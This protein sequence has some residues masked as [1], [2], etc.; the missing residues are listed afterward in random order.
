M[1]NMQHHIQFLHTSL[2]TRGTVKH[3]CQTQRH[4]PPA[5]CSSRSNHSQI[6]SAPAC[7]VK[8]RVNLDLAHGSSSGLPS[9][10]QTRQ[11][12]RQCK[13]RSKTTMN[14]SCPQALTFGLFATQFSYSNSCLLQHPY[15]HLLTI[16]VFDEKIK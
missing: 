9:R 14:V 7:G 1:K 10:S 13:S 12:P 16:P 8:Y 6:A 4:L 3:E 2:K 11:S 5:S 15:S